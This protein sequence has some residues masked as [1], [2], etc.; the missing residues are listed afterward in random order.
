MN[1]RYIISKDF[2][3]PI[4]AIFLVITLVGVG[5]MVGMTMVQEIHKTCDSSIVIDSAG[6]FG[7]QVH[8][9]YSNVTNITNLNWT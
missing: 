8:H 7:F 1:L 4:I 5:E 9:D 2:L 6:M 3:Y